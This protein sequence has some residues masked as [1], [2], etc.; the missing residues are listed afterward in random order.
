[1]VFEGTNSKFTRPKI[2]ILWQTS[3]S[4]NNNKKKNIKLKDIGRIM[5]I[6]EEK[7]KTRRKMRVKVR[8]PQ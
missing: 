4:N 5:A 2:I 6:S 1:M 7:D 8:I 3:M